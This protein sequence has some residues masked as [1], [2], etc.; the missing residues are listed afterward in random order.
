MVRHFHRALRALKKSPET[1]KGLDRI[2]GPA[3]F[4]YQRPGQLEP[5]VEI[6]QLPRI[7]K[8]LDERFYNQYLL[9]SKNWCKNNAV[10]WAN[11]KDYLNM[12]LTSLSSKQRMDMNDSLKPEVFDREKG[13]FRML[14][15]HLLESPLK[16][17]DLV[18]LRSDPSQLCMCV[19]VPTEVTN[20]SYAFATIDGHIRFGERNMILLRI[21]S[22]HKSAANY[23]IKEEV[24]YLDARIGTVKD[25]PEKTFTLPIVA[26]QL[27]TS[28]V[29]FEITKAA[30]NRMGM[31]TKKLEL[32]HR[33]LQRSTGPWQM[34]I[35]RLCELVAL[36]DIQKCY[37]SSTG[38]YIEGVM[39][40]AG[41][42]GTAHPS[43]TSFGHPLKS[44]DASDFLAT[45]WSL[46]QQQEQ[47]LWG[48]IHTHRA[49]LTPISV[50]V[51]PLALHHL[52][53]EDVLKELKKDN[54]AALVAFAKLINT[55]DYNSAKLQ[56]PQVSRLLRDYAA[57]NFH[58]NGPIITIVS[59]LFRKLD[60][61]Q[62]KDITRD[63][64]HEFLQ[65]FSCEL[66]P[67][68]QLLS[69]EIH[70]PSTSEEALL[71]QK[72]YDLA[73]PIQ[74]DDTSRRHD[75]GN[76]NVYCIDSETAHEIDDGISI[77]D[78]GNN[79]YILHIHIADPVSLFSDSQE[80]SLSE[81]IWNIA[82]QRGFTS[83]LPDCVTPMLPKGY[84]KAGDLGKDGIAS[85]T[86]SFSIGIKCNE[87]SIEI[88][89]ETFDVKLGLVS[90]FPRVTYKIVDRILDQKQNTTQQ[91][92]ELRALHKI[93]VLLRSKRV[94]EQN[95]IIFGEG[96]NR[97][98]VKLTP[99]DNSTS[100]SL[101]FE[102]QEETA[103]T[104][105]VSEIMI[106]ANTMAGK[107]FR[108][109]G[110]PGVFR[111]YKGL[112]LKNNALKGYN[113]LRDMM[114]SQT[115]PSAQDIAKISSLLNSSFYSARAEEHEMIG[116]PAYLPVT[117]PLRRFADLVNH[118]QL[119]CH[120]AGRPLK[121]SEDQVSDLAWHI[122]SRD[123]VLRKAARDSASFW[124]LVHLK[125][126][127][128]LNPSRR[129]SVMVTSVPRLGMVRCVLPELSSARGT[130]KLKPEALSTAAIGDV[131][132]N[133]KITR[134]DCLDGVME[135]EM[136]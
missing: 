120:L 115:F 97:G 119:H 100:A 17:G 42:C 109:R 79:S 99:A 54:Y 81:E 39:R 11:M 60:K 18:L 102:D 112:Q 45:Y 90:Q 8:G 20:P 72:V 53:F 123:V 64:C 101:T 47:N 98:L 135:L 33:F 23:L 69:N 41:M 13:T 130:L 7:Q 57:G 58:N 31:T 111:C 91:A 96:F 70:L 66:I 65:E 80:G 1:L 34:S 22:F 55:G 88:L 46:V 82:L 44:I 50:T 95:A 124:T 93:A 134:L 61:Y 110:I 116:A 38:S 37:S 103:S 108:D 84:S 29:P 40:E 6:K 92:Q 87:G 43:K 126:Q 56:Y 32:L 24:P 30:W 86:L 26:R 105:L 3:K 12:D 75:F 59:K 21:P 136:Q 78:M 122:Q 85:K 63:L 83:Y 104:I 118:W 76:M 114:H 19:E 62:H 117:S 106:L 132:H 127:Q 16:I 73:L 71:E 67:N 107:F 125:S 89:D 48:Q 15:S 5:G 131:V 74:S 52:Y 25:S 4:V 133:C 49:M 14:P 2:P 36:L 9:P 77:E 128:K 113:S 94:K 10:D 129:L 28:Y 68:P 121:F 51:L 35:F 27:Y